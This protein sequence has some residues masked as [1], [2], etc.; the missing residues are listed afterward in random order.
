VGNRTRFVYVGTT[1]RIDSLVDPARLAYKF[2]YNSRG[3]VSEIW[4]RGSGSNSALAA[5]LM[6]DPTVPR[7]TSVKIW[8]SATQGDSTRFHYL[9]STSYGAYVDSVYDPRH[10]ST[11]PIVTAFNYD[12]VTLTPTLVQRPAPSAG[13]VAGLAQIRDAWRRAVPRVGRGRPGQMAER[14]IWADQLRGTLLPFVGR[15]TDYQVDQFGGPTW[16]MNPA[17]PPVITPDFLIIS[18]GADDE[19]RI[20]RDSVGRVTKIVRTTTRVLQSGTAVRT[21]SVMYSYHALD[22]IERVIRPTRRYPVP[23]SPLF[24]TTTFSWTYKTLPA[25]GGCTVL[26]RIVDEM[27][28]HTV[29]DYGAS[30]AAQCLPRIIV[31]PGPSSGQAPDTTRFA[32]GSLVAGDPAGPRPI[33]ITDP[34]GVSVS[35]DYDGTTWNSATSMR[36]SDNATSRAFYGPYGWPDSTKDAAGTR[37][38]SEYDQSGRV[39]RA[40][41]GSGATAPTVATFFNAGGLVDSNRVYQSSD[42]ELISVLD[43]V[44]TTKHFYNRLGWLD[45]TLTP[46]RRSQRYQLFDGWGH[47][48]WEFRGNGAFI[49]RTYDNYGR[50]SWENQSAV[51]PSYSADG[52]PFAEPRADSVY[53]S[54]GLNFTATLSAGQ[55]HQ[56]TYDD[57]G[58]VGRITTWDVA[59][60]ATIFARSYGYSPTGALIADTLSFANGPTIARSYQYNRRGQRTV[61]ATTITGITVTEARDSLFYRYDSLT[62]RLDSLVGKVDSSGSRNYAAVR[63]LYDRAGRDTLQRVTVYSGGS[64][65]ILSTRTTYDAS[66]RLNLLSSTSAAGTWYSLSGPIYNR[67]DHLKSFAS[68]EPG[69]ANG[70]PYDFNFSSVLTYDSVGGTW[71]LLRSEKTRESNATRTQQYGYDLP[72]NRISEFR[73]SGFAEGCAQN[74]GDASTFGPDNEL[75]RTLNSCSVRNRYWHDKAGN[76]LVQ[77]DTNNAGTYLGPQNILSYTAKGQLFFAMSPTAQVGTYD[78]NWHWYDAT[79]RRMITLRTTGFNWAPSTI[80]TGGA[81][82]FYVYDGDDVALSLVRNGS[83]AWWVKA[84][85]LVGGL[86]NAVAGRFHSEAGLMRNLALIN[87]RQGTTLAAMRGDG[88]QEDNVSYFTKDPYGGLIGASGPES[89]INTETGFAGAS[90]PNASGGFVYLRNRWYDPKTGKFLTQD[91]IGLAGG[92]NLYSYAG[93]NPVAFVDPFGLCPPPP[94]TFDLLCTAANVAAGFG[95]A[96]TFGLTAKIRGE[97]ADAQVDKSSVAYFGGEIAGVAASAALGGA[98]AKTIQGG[99]T[100][101]T[102]GPA[103][104]I[105]TKLVK[106]TPNLLGRGGR[107]NSGRMLRIGVGKHAGRAILRVAGKVVRAASGAEH[108]NLIELGKMATWY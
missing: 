35:V 82:T 71:R 51:G 7:L 95:D 103:R 78:H 64:S 94:G 21:D 27:G 92:V 97:E 42:A 28:A 31:G 30:G 81:K 66:G 8:R 101:A 96:V 87:D 83:G 69:I 55:F 90:T 60:N 84:R 104:A 108:I 105:G 5:S 39:V 13:A 107:L 56:F 68:R 75:V 99:G 12:A 49:T 25:G 54:L 18:F 17:P 72:G 76:R 63:W 52:R 33:Q 67:I 38:F 29:L 34:S 44:R 58:G 10:K 89:P 53:K 61:A 40:K 4:R 47:P 98:I 80:T 3:L 88:T 14:L 93:N 32:Y 43:S 2:Q 45:S 41:A 62:A 74:G 85:Y 57:W 100:L 86:D 106:L 50:L 22:R 24:D 77:L 20:A 59:A 70:P 26:T 9:T 15:R 73:T 91:P 23:A 65:A 37:T 19:R 46:G 102:S 6:Y 79:G 1:S 36:L 48:V 16:V 11:N